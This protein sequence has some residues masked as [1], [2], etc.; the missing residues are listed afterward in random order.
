LP[1]VQTKKVDDLVNPEKS[2]NPVTQKDLKRGVYADHF[3]Q[4][5]WS[6]EPSGGKQAG[7]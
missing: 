2:C 1:Q 4:Q 6:E 7:D 3:L 5:L